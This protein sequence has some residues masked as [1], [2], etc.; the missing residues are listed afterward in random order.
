VSGITDYDTVS[1]QA[2]A[3]QTLYVVVSSCCDPSGAGDYLLKIEML[4]EGNVC[5]DIIDLGS[6]TS[7]DL[8]SVGSTANAPYYS[9][10]LSCQGNTF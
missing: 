2:T 9:D 5:K 6:M 4:D 8:V 3:Q 10:M 1:R 7:E